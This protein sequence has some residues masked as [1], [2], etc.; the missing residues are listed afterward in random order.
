M[1]GKKLILPLLIRNDAELIKTQRPVFPLSIYSRIF[2]KLLYNKIL[3]LF[4][5][6]NFSLQNWTLLKTWES[7]INQLLSIIHRMYKS[8][9]DRQE[10]RGVL[11]NISKP[12]ENVCHEN[13]IYKLKQDRILGNMLKIVRDSCKLMPQNCFEQKYFQLGWDNCWNPLRI[14]CWDHSCF[15]LYE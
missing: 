9:N 13:V 10:I 2:E 8:V 6:N 14:H 4:I 7:C 12:F 11:L 3:S 1:S 5:T 15:N